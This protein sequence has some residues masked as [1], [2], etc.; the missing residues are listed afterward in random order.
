[1]I[2]K[3]GVRQ[4]SNTDNGANDLRGK[5]CWWYAIDQESC[6]YYDD[7]DFT[8]YTMCCA[9]QTNFQRLSDSDLF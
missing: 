8:A 6:G 7:D 4:C 2:G 1:M 3:L 9:C 5:T